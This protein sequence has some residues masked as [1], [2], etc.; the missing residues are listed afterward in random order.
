MHAKV[1]EVQ[2]RPG[3]MEG[4]I[5]IFRDTFGASSTQE[6][7]LFSAQLLTDSG[8]GRVL[9]LLV[10][11]NASDLTAVEA[12]GYF[13]ALIARFEP[14][15]AAPAHTGRYE[16]SVLPQPGGFARD[17]D[18]TEAWRLYSG[19]PGSAKNTL[20]TTFAKLYDS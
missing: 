5:D 19:A 9:M 8:T 14:V 2:I 12:R 20:S 6:R 15:L 11:E 17:P 13:Q 16:V 3:K 18:Y 10:W 4:T 7:G 1:I